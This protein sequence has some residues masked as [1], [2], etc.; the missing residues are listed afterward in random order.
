MK[1]TRHTGE[2]IIA[3]LNRGEAGLT[4]VESC[5]QHG[6]SEQTYYRW[7]AKYGAMGSSEDLRA[8]LR[9]AGHGG[10]GSSVARMSG[11]DAVRKLTRSGA[12]LTL[13]TK[14]W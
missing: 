12:V 5:R 1:G 9:A 11:N 7:K 3:I 4:T 14:R 6:I 8:F 10:G 13:W 2:Q